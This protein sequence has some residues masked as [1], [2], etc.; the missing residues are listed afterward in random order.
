MATFRVDDIARLLPA[1]GP[2]LTVY[3]IAHAASLRHP[4]IGP[5]TVSAVL[6]VLIRECR[7]VRVDAPDG[8]HRYHLTENP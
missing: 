8:N 6:A 2:G 3:A 5:A 1:A 4:G 7:A